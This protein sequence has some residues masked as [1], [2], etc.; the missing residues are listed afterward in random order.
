M[1]VIV[2][3]AVVEIGL[4]PPTPAP[5]QSLPR[6]FLRL[7]VLNIAANLAVPLAGLVD[8]AMLGHLP[9]LSFLAGV[10]LASLIFDYLYWSFGFLRMSTTGLTAQALGRNDEVEAH[11]VLYRAL[12]TAVAVGVA[13]WLL[14]EP[15]RQLSFWLLS[16][17]A[18]VEAAGSA[19]YTAR[20]WAAPAAL[21]NF[22]LLGWFL[23][24]EES[25]RAL[26]MTMVAG[27]SNI[28]FN[29]VFIVRM[30]WAAFGAGLGTM[31]SQVLMLLVALTMFFRRPR[32]AL[33][34]RRVLFRRDRWIELF[35]LNGDILVRTLCL[36]TTFALF[37]NF[38][39]I[40]GT[41]I[42]A[43]NAV[44]QRLLNFAAYLIDGVAYATESLAG[45]LKGAGSRG[46]LR[47]LLRLAFVSGLV[48]AALCLAALFVGPEWVY[49]LLTSHDDVIRDA[50]RYG[51]WL[52][53]AL[54]LGTL[55]YV[56]DGL[57]L[58]L[59]AGRALRNSMVISTVL[60][61]LPLA[62]TALQLESNHLLWLALTAFMA[63]RAAT[64]GWASRPLLESAS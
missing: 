49:G 52:I 54:L 59:T 25:G 55:A 11:L 19:Y 51:I 57:F 28:A 32:P 46:G 60:V 6:R 14:Q 12:V 58:G 33:P 21:A 47:R 7:T 20:I 16:G 24:R 15:L 27:F 3:H 62:W 43:V 13:L 34:G 23:G 39:S 35:R 18:A 44:L 48:F 36:M 30:G 1:G 26:V 63:A 22:A 40:L 10:A 5:T 9:D 38:S 64:L 31:L 2:R 50:L 4:M 42:L 29:Y 8:V 37:L 61:F 45:V 41:G 53:P 56:Y 17:D